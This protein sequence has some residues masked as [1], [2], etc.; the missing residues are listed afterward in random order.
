VP[1]V[2]FGKKSKNIATASRR[3]FG[4]RPKQDR[5]AAGLAVQTLEPMEDEENVMTPPPPEES[6]VAGDPTQRLLTA[7]GRFQRQVVRAEEGASQEAWCDECMN[8]LISGIE[9]AVSEDWVDVK[10]ALTDTAR[11]LA[12]YEK[13]RS[14]DQ[15]IRF[16]KDSYEI[17]CLMVGDL[18]VGN[19][20]SGVLKKWQERY[21]RALDELAE[22]GL[23]LVDDDESGEREAPREREESHAGSG[24]DFDDM[25][26]EGTP[27]DAPGSIF[28]GDADPSAPGRAFSTD[29]DDPFAPV[30]LS[31]EEDTV[32]SPFEPPVDFGRSDTATGEQPSLDDLLGRPV[33]PDDDLDDEEPAA[34]APELSDDFT[35]ETEFLGEEDAGEAEESAHENEAVE[36]DLES[37]ASSEGESFETADANELD[38]GDSPELD[39]TTTQEPEVDAAVEN[40]ASDVEEPSHTQEAT[41]APEHEPAPGTAEAL[42]KTAQMA[43]AAGNVSDAK[44]F[45][46]QLAAS[47]A[48]LEAE[49]VEGRISSIEK[50]IERN[51]ESVTAGEL[52]VNEAEERVRKLEEE[53]ERCQREF[54][55]KQQHTGKLRDEAEAVASAVE[56]LNRQIAELEARRDAEAERLAACQANLEDS[57]GEEGRM[58]AELESLRDEASGSRENL[59]GARSR[60]QSLQEAGAGHAAAL[61]STLEELAKRRRSVEEI[62]NTIR[63][64]DGGV[65]GADAD[66]DKVPEQTE[67]LA[68]SAGEEDGVSGENSPDEPSA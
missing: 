42:L 66:A 46:L 10:E 13:A 7:L 62:Q 54:E 56:D 14:A 50:D 20:R 52:A 32:G 12:T 48:A 11:V 23:T 55:E 41:P 24:E 31:E 19:A 28:D 35:A 67:L 3:F 45:A 51:S 8:Q 37:V 57:V 60:V 9:I 25:V 26:E 63:H 58:Q 38:F 18:I 17:L 6:M 44:L 43:M 49:Q 1:K 34:P 15:C 61:E 47:M 27:E 64:V 2:R 40:T 22:S 5:Q 30:G 39:S 29:P 21:E 33:S 53:T 65:A 68:E 4:E 16:L 59:E 36:L